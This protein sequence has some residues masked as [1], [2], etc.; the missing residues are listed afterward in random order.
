MSRIRSPKKLSVLL[1][2]LRGTWTSKVSKIIVHIPIT[3]DKVH[4]FGYFG[5]PRRHVE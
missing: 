3:Y 1:R 5:G 4:E 2:L